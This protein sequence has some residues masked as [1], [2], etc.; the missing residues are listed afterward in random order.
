MIEPFI[1]TP[2]QY[3]DQPFADF[4]CIFCCCKDCVKQK[5]A[6]VP[7]TGESDAEHKQEN[8]QTIK[9]KQ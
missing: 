2:L 4:V 5:R 7:Q 9:P 1:F 6:F 3:A 8:L